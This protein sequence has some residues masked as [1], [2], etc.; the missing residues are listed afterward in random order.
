MDYTYLALEF[1][2]NFLSIRCAYRRKYELQHFLEEEFKNKTTLSHIMCFRIRGT[3]NE[4]VDP[5][6]IIKVDPGEA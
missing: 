5:Y 3:K 4:R 2:P 6:E 1:E